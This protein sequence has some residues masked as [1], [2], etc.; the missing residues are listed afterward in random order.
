MPAHV[1]QLHARAAAWYE[2][3]GH[4]ANA[5]SHA[6]AA[7]DTEQAANLVERAA[8]G[9]AMRGEVMT[10]LQWVDALPDEAVIA[11][12]Y[13]ALTYAWS[14]L[15]GGEPAEEVEH[16]LQVVEARE[17]IAAATGAIRGYVELFEGELVAASSHAREALRALPEQAL[18]LRQLSTLVLGMA[19]RYSD[20]G[21]DPEQALVDASQAGTAAEN[22]L[23]AVL[24]H[25]AR[26]DMALRQGEMAEGQAIYELALATATDDDGRP[27]PVAS[28]PLF[29]LATL[30]LERFELAEAEQMV[31]EG[32]D[33][34]QRWS[35]LA[36]LDGYLLQARIHRLRGEDKA[37][38][39]QLEKAATA[40]RHFDAT[41]VDDLIVA[42]SSIQA[43]IRLG[44]LAEA[45]RWLDSRA[46]QT[47][48]AAAELAN[49]ASQLRKYEYLLLARLLIA[50]GRP[51]EAVALLDTLRP[52][53]ER[54]RARIMLHLLSA[55][56]HE[57]MG[58]RQA[59]LAALTEALTL[60]NAAGMVAVFVEEGMPVARLLYR[61][62][63]EEEGP[64]FPT[65]DT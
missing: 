55:V 64:T 3:Q 63:E 45:R 28:E 59:A 11:R 12:P 7:C 21:P 22:I 30:A 53:F 43:E 42:L 65:Y 31:E 32:I 4:M 51:A 56:V 1:P 9:A 36:A 62:L 26:A 47:T 50:E 34:A 37:M 18:F 29:G 25:C 24:G 38:W 33:L 39:T 2:A 8:E 44:H 46:L 6:L 60:G 41:E 58:E 35:G 40:A 54:Y 10:L 15:V 61:A 49:H 16:W 5:I 20:S 14:L 27:L 19:S 23:V 52:H 17:E 13:L 48:A 57:Q